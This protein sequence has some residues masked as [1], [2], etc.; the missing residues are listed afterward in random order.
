MQK[1]LDI[2]LT[3]R[4][5]EATECVACGLALKHV[6]RVEL[7]SV[8]EQFIAQLTDKTRESLALC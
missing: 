1:A 2:I 3:G 4:W 8:A 6:G 7:R 5:L